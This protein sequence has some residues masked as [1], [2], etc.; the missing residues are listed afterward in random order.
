M[1]GTPAQVPAN[2][3]QGDPIQLVSAGCAVDCVV[4]AG[5]K[6]VP[7]EQSTAYVATA[8]AAGAPASLH[9]V[10]GDHSAMIDPTSEA[11]DTVGAL[12]E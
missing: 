3:A 10:P 8:Q 5:D 1:G 9:E 11:W 6:I 7:R 2:Y 4:G 12:I